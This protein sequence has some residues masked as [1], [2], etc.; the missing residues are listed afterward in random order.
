V[1]PDPSLEPSGLEVIE[2]SWERIQLVAR[3]R[4]DRGAGPDPV[5][6]FLRHATDDA[7]PL[8]GRPVER[9]TTPDELLVRFNPF[10]ATNQMPLA[11]G[12]WLLVARAPGSAGWQGVP[13][14]SSD[15]VAGQARS[16]P[17]GRSVYAVQPAWSAT[18]VQRDPL[19]IEISVLRLNAPGLKTWSPASLRAR[20]RRRLTATRHLAFRW[21]LVLCR[22]LPGATRLVV[23]TSDSRARIGGNLA[24]VHERMVERGLDQEYDLRTI[25]RASLR[26]SRR[27]VDRARL[28]WL[29][30]RA[31][32]ILLED[33]QPAVYRLEPRPDR[34][35][36]QLWHAWGAFKT[37]G[38]SRIGKPGGLSPFARAHRN[39]TYAIVSS[40]HEVPFYAEAFALP[41]D[42]VVPTGTPRMDDFLDPRKQAARREGALAAMPRARGREVIL[43]APTFRGAGARTADYPIEMIDLPAA[44]TL[45][46]ERDAIL[47]V[48]LHPFVERRL[49]VPPS[50]AE[51]IVDASDLP[52]DTNDL[53]LISDLLVTDYSSLIFE[54]AA[55]GRPMLFFAYDQEEYV[56]TRDFYE[57]YETFVPGRIVRS[58][59]ELMTA[60]RARDYQAEKVEPF[61]RR[62]LPSEPGSATDRI[63]DQLILGR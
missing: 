52:V 8:E 1:T 45:C 23:F 14:A 15:V 10:A 62:H 19:S 28:V 47:L 24:L 3:L 36:I 46:R 29:L 6:L 56:A 39:Y 35:I 59:D 18:Q 42:Q 21:L 9:P 26:T 38:Y 43:F 48:R 61:A 55:L 41:E 37:V 12:A 4:R 20:L 13:A 49:D 11:P 51:R 44:D 31:R 50:M 25:F 2:L 32:V 40:E 53:L 63:I 54:Y 17:F 7:P 57:P 60:I 33:V 58:F 16:F 22:A 34:R 5:S 27:M 30:A